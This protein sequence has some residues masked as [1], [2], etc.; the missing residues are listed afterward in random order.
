MGDSDLTTP[1]EALAVDTQAAE[2]IKAW[3]M[4]Q[5]SEPARGGDWVPWLVAGVATAGFVI[6][7]VSAVLVVR[8]HG[9]RVVS[10]PA[11]V[12]ATATATVT[13]VPPAGVPSVPAPVPQ[14][15]RVFVAAMEDQGWPVWDPEKLSMVGREVC[16]LAYRGA[17]RQA[18]AR[19]VH[20]R[21]PGLTF[22]DAQ[23]LV[24]TALEVYPNCQPS[25]AI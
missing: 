20:A 6:A 8:G 3:S 11:T 23:E 19:G 15:D 16:D 2:T 14:Y 7:C 24:D 10:E 21:Y 22:E 1:A 9:E 18:L 13:T 5:P 25:G 4:E 17:G 12:T